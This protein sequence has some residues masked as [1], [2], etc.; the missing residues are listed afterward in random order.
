MV[1]VGQ[2]VEVSTVR[3]MRGGWEPLTVVGVV[4]VVES[5]PWG[6]D[7]RIDLTPPVL[8]G[9]TEFNVPV[10]WLSVSVGSDKIT[11]VA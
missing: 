4:T 6:T 2:R 10:E 1:E 8:V 7:A 9:H 11:V 3:G 5:R